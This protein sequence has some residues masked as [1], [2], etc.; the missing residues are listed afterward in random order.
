V[1]KG[2][3][4]GLLVFGRFCTYVSFCRSLNLSDEFFA[5]GVGF[6]EELLTQRW[7]SGNGISAVY[8]ILKTFVD[9]H[10]SCHDIVVGP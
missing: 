8:R 3:V 10:N 4:V 5:S 6:V 1:A 7:G 2:H 9:L